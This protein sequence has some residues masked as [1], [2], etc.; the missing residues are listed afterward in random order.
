[1][2]NKKQN[3]NQNKNHNNKPQNQNKQQN[4][5]WKNDSSQFFYYNYGKPRYL[6]WNCRNK[7]DA[8]LAPQTNLTVDQL[9]AMI[10]EDNVVDR[11]EEWWVDISVSCHVCYDRAMF[12]SYSNVMD[13]IV[14]LIDS[15][16]TVV[17]SIGKVEPKF[18]FVTISHF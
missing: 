11:S 10:S 3:R 6:G 2:K 17:T 1:M 12:K 14:L 4:P 7:R 15:Y 13:M 18:T 16:S 5:S 9:V 8:R